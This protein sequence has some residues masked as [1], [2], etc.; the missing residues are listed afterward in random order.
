MVMDN[1]NGLFEMVGGAFIFL[2]V[3]KLHKDKKV[4]GVS[5][6]A[7]TFFT[8]WGFWNLAYYPALGQWWS[9]L[10]ASSVAL[11]NMIWLGQIVYYNRKEKRDGHAR[12]TR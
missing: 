4:K 5:P 7:I 2:N 9:A 3:L 6:V 1:I 8:V 10:G 11:I 12:E